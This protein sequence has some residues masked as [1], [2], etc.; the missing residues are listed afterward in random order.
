M[1]VVGIQL[2]ISLQGGRLTIIAEDNF[3]SRQIRVDNVF[4][5]AGNWMRNVGIYYLNGLAHMAFEMTTTPVT[6][7]I[8]T[9]RLEIAVHSVIELYQYRDIDLFRPIMTVATS[10]GATDFIVRNA[11]LHIESFNPDIFDWDED[12]GRW[13]A[14]AQGHVE[15]AC[16]WLEY[17]LT[18]GISFDVEPFTPPPPHMLVTWSGLPEIRNGG[19][20]KPATIT[21]YSGD[22]TDITSQCEFTFEHS[23]TTTT[24]FVNGATTTAPSGNQ[25]RWF[26]TAPN[27]YS[28]R[29]GAV[30]IGSTVSVTVNAMHP[31]HGLISHTFSWLVVPL[32]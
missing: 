4:N 7:E 15:L 25:F 30:T 3:C 31:I 9:P 32:W 26:F 28:L 12:I 24:T 5:L 18:T 27:T 19:S 2:S 8:N 23:F 11:T 16:T 10:S 6:I 20:A 29:A 14:K 22:D 1:M 13:V 17:G 21:V